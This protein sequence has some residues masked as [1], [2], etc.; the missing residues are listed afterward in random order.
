MPP[1]PPSKHAR[2]H[3][4]LDVERIQGGS[5]R[6]DTYR[7]MRWTVRAVS[8]AS[9][10]RSYLCPGCQQDIAPGVPHVVVW[11]A[12]GVGRSRGPAALAQR[13]LAAP[14]CPAGRQRLPMNTVGPASCAAVRSRTESTSAPRR[15]CQLAEQS[16][17]AYGRVGAEPAGQCCC[18]L[19]T[20]TSS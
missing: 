4:P 18:C 11:P 17:A 9:A 8:G 6:E 14:R 12:E 16:P 7:G 3:V 15:R 20:R 13:L 1:T 10:T 5:T 2:Q 19:G